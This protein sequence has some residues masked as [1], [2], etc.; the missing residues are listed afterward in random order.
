MVW[1]AGKASGEAIE[2]G[3]NA[4]SESVTARYEIDQAAS[5]GEWMGRNLFNRHAGTVQL[6][7]GTIDVKDGLLAGGHLTVDMTTLP[8]TDITDPAVREGNNELFIFRKER[9]K[10]KIHR[11]LFASTN[12][13]EAK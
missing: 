4:V 10:W 2:Q 3:T 7:P 6:G 1:K 11:Y 13:P 12:P 8:C 5:V 9:G